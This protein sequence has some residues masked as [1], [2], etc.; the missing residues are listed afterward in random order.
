MAQ[1]KFHHEEIYRGEDLVHKLSAFQLVV[2]GGGAIGSNLVDN[3]TR[4][5]FTRVRVI[6]MDRV[7]AH[8]IGTQIFEEADIGALK[9]NAIQNHV[10]RRVHTEIEVIG[11]ELTANNVKKFLKGADLVIDAFDN[12]ASRKLVHNYCRGCVPCLAAGLW[13]DYGET[14]WNEYYKVPLDGVGDICNYPLARNIITL[15]VAVA[16]EEIIDFCLSPKPR[17]K[18]WSITLK[19][20]TVKEMSLSLWN[21]V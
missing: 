3:L 11:K 21:E 15:T 17:K 12:S 13:E 16:S 1:S 9:V 8:N 6:D 5:G 7:E 4:Q 14:V 2:C 20:L 19:D 18:N 10:F